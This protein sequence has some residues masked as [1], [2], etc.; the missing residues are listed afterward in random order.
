MSAERFPVD[1]PAGR[2]KVGVATRIYQQE[3]MTHNLQ[4]PPAA[5][6]GRTAVSS[7]RTAAGGSFAGR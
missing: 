4:I 6:P 3:V 2:E 1:S 7:L 5:G